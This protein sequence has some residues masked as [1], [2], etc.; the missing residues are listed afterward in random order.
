[1][2]SALSNVVHVELSCTR[3]TSTWWSDAHLFACA[4]HM[5][6]ADTMGLALSNVV[7]VELSCTR[8]TSFEIC[9]GSVRLASIRVMSTAK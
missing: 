2:G 7:H 3:A 6:S 9:A 8:A 5:Y 1:M 4:L